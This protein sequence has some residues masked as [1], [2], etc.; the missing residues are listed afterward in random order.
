MVERQAAEAALGTS[1]SGGPSGQGGARPGTGRTAASGAAIA[2]GGAASFAGDAGGL[3]EARSAVS[4]GYDGEAQL[5]G[6][7]YLSAD[8][9]PI[10]ATGF[11]LLRDAAAATGGAFAGP[12]IVLDQDGRLAAVP[13]AMPQAVLRDSDPFRL[14]LAV[15]EPP[16]P[17]SAFMS[18]EARLAVLLDKGDHN[19][20]PTAAQAHVPTASTRGYS[21][22]DVAEW[23][24][25]ESA[26]A[27]FAEAEWLARAGAYLEG[28]ASVDDF[29]RAVRRRM[30]GKD[31]LSGAAEPL[32]PELAVS[33]ASA[34]AVAAAA[35][36]PGGTAGS[37]G[38]A[39]PH[40]GGRDD[41]WD[42]A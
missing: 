20:L 24:R 29:V 22:G 12:A 32:P 27:G 15:G 14:R 8:A 26:Y 38:G 35:A 6:S 42:P 39:G 10:G 31:P 18:N 19:R 7:A 25:L 33:A 11:R 34:A 13:P 17:A 3:G 2:F 5:E 1:A 30:Q 28:R 9:L 21:S 41:V 40:V 37:A 16:P 4:L 36:G 23:L